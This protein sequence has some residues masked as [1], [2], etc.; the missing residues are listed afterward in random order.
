MPSDDNE[1]IDKKGG[2]GDC[3][4]IDA[5]TEDLSSDSEILEG[6]VDFVP[7]TPEEHGE[8]RGNQSTAN[9]SSKRR[10]YFL[11]KRRKDELSQQEKERIDEVSLREAMAPSEQEILLQDSTDEAY[12]PGAYNVDNREGEISR[13]QPTSPS[14]VTGGDDTEDSRLEE[15][16]AATG[17][18]AVAN[19]VVQ[20]DADFPVATS[21]QVT[22]AAKQ[23]N[24]SRA[25]WAA[26]AIMV[27]ILVGVSVLI[28]T[29]F[30]APNGRGS[31]EQQQQP[32]SL[33]IVE[34]ENPRSIQSLLPS[35][36]IKSIEEEGSPQARAYGWL[37]GDPSWQDYSDKRIVQR[38]AMA[39]FYFATNGH[40]WVRDT[41][42]LSYNVSE[43]D[44]YHKFSS[45]DA[46]TGMNLTVVFKQM[47]GVS[48]ELDMLPRLQTTGF[49]CMPLSLL[50]GPDDNEEEDTMRNLMFQSN[51][52]RG[53]IPPELY[54]LT[55][56]RS[57]VLVAG[58][59]LGG[60]IST[61]IG[62]LSHLKVLA[63]DSC[64]LT[65]TLPSEIGQATELQVITF[66]TNKL[67]GTI[68]PELSELANLL[69]LRLVSN[70]LTGGVPSD[71]GGLADLINLKI[72]DNS[73]TSIPPEIG[74]LSSLRVLDVEDNSLAV[75]PSEIGVMSNLEYIFLNGNQ[76]SLVPSALWQLENLLYLDISNNLLSGTIMSDMSALSA[77]QTLYVNGN[78]LTGSIPE[79]LCP[80]IPLLDCTAALCGCNCTCPDN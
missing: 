17:V 6:S 63:I 13:R 12:Q 37:L 55:S 48:Y 71:L 15:G 41:G 42:W 32:K 4:N 72:G 9:T 46:D 60:T 38:F 57:V 70:N 7:M 40:D 58:N 30:S 54:L 53:T 34:P 1:A 29:L 25:R 16:E 56:L 59:D 47:A 26:S 52:L 77:L 73:L 11:P 78:N 75:I 65:G 67:H 49:P 14:M 31:A 8:A 5:Q 79:S 28:A 69:F 76:L 51:A 2:S 3:N 66:A 21:L 44:W 39:T 62:N 74:G 18:L 45:T 27:V 43:C 23:L 64:D 22:R 35:Y 80:K 61:L 50:G 10:L 24:R 36:T 33:T 19:L 68:P 20:E